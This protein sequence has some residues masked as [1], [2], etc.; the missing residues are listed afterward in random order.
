MCAQLGKGDGRHVVPVDENGKATGKAGE[1]PYRVLDLQH[2]PRSGR[3]LI[4]DR[5]ALSPPDTRQ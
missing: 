4:V 3:Q 2:L 5:R 1:Q